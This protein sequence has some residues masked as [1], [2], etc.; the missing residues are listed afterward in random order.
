[1]WTSGAEDATSF[2]VWGQ[3]L[4]T[5]ISQVNLAE[6]VGMDVSW[7]GPVC[8]NPGNAWASPA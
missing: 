7:Y 3:R 2:S 5:G 6:S 1:M 8:E 4:L